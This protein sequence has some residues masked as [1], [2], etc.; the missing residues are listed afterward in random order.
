LPSGAVIGFD[1]DLGVEAFR[2]PM[3]SLASERREMTPGYDQKPL[4]AMMP[5]EGRDVFSIGAYDLNRLVTAFA[6]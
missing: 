5:H 2:R 1:G 3:V 6:K 4:A